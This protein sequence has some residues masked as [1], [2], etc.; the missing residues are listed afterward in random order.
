VRGREQ[1]WR[2]RSNCCVAVE[3]KLFCNKVME[4]GDG[5]WAGVFIFSFLGKVKSYLESYLDES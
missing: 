5:R 1:W 4:D 3:E 2:R